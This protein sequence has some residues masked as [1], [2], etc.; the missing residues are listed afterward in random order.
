MRL[1]RLAVAMVVAVAM[2]PLGA[3]PAQALP[4]VTEQCRFSDA[5]FTEISG[6]TYS[7]RHPDVIYLHNDSS[8]GPRV[9]AV[10]ARTCATLATITLAGI[11][12]RDLEA[13]GSGRDRKGRPVI[14]VGDIGDNRDSWPEVRL[15]R[16][17][18]PAVL[19]DQTLPVRTYRFTYPDGPVN[20]EALLTDPNGLRVWVA[21]KKLAEGRIYRVP[22]RSGA[23]AV[24]RPVGVAGGLTTDGSISPAGDR[25]VLRD[26]VDAEVRSG[27]PP[28]QDPF[29]VYL[30]I[31]PQG[32]AITWTPD[33]SALLVAGERDDRLLRV[34]IEPAPVA[35]TA[36]SPS[37]SAPSSSAGPSDTTD[38]SGPGP[39]APQTVDGGW[40][41]WLAGGLVL[42]ALAVL[43]SAEWRRRRARHHPAPDGTR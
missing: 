29:T 32:E 14:W 25:F 8:G 16:F 15:H 40:G 2:V 36:A 22:L 26:Y 38:A 6:M 28:G 5:R 12:A 34:A 35:S 3:I 37:A 7:Q 33:G 41:A 17:R 18:E 42:L 19:R 23:V 24:A 9:Y 30:P 39:L 21:T 27:R 4:G 13:I 43:A 11:E 10:D 1:V 31:Q 20:A